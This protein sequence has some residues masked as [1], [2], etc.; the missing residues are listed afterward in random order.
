MTP[1][2]TAADLTTADLIRALFP[3]FLLAAAFFT[4]VI[5]AVLSRRFERQRSAAM[6]ALAMALALSV[7]LVWWEAEH[8]YSIR[9]LGPLAVGFALLLLASVMY[10][11]L[12]DVAGRFSGV[13][14][15]L[16]VSLLIGWSLELPWPVDV[17][18][19]HTLTVVALVAGVLAIDYAAG[20][21]AELA[22][23]ERVYSANEIPVVMMRPEDLRDPAAGWP[24]GPPSRVCRL[25]ACWKLTDAQ[26][27][28]P[29]IGA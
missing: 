23:R 18:I 27:L 25:S 24:F 28:R 11:S 7:G 21:R 15:A 2:D 9:D 29:A 4:S 16:G 10:R 12:K 14:L 22:E 17:E 13:G 20:D 8:G 3:D 1:L 26:R 19:I 5:Y 6:A